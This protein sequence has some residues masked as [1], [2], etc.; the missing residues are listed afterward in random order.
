MQ[1]Y[2][3]ENDYLKF[4]VVLSIYCSKVH[5]LVFKKITLLAKGTIISKLDEF[6]LSKNSTQPS[7]EVTDGQQL[8]DYLQQCNVNYFKQALDITFAQLPLSDTLPSF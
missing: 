7:Q 5:W 1:Q 4:Q 8:Q 6:I 2:L 3:Q